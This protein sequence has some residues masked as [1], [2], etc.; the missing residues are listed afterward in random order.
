MLCSRMRFFIVLGLMFVFATTW[1]PAN[2]TV[3]DSTTKGFLKP[4]QFVVWAATADWTKNG[5]QATATGVN[6]GAALWDVHENLM[7]GGA[8]VVA[9][10]VP[11]AAEIGTADS[12][13][14]LKADMTDEQLRAYKHYIVFTEVMWG[15][16]SPYRK[17]AQ[18]L[19]LYCHSGL[20]KDDVI[21]MRQHHVLLPAPGETYMRDHD[22]DANTPERKYVVLDR[23][24]TVDR[25]GR[26]WALKGTNGNTDGNSNTGA[27]PENMV[28]MYRKIE[29]DS[30]GTGYQFENG[31][32]KGLGSG[33][34]ASSWEASTGRI[35]LWSFYTGSPG[36]VHVP[37]G[38]PTV[39]MFA[40]QPDFTELPNIIINEVRNDPSSLNFDWIELFY[41]SENA[42]DPPVNI[43]DYELSLVM[44]KMKDDGSGYHESGDANFTDTSL[45]VLPEYEMMPGEYLVVYNRDPGRT[46]PLADGVN[47]QDLLDETDIKKG[48]MHKYVVSTDLKL[49][50]EGKFLILLRTRNSADDV[51]KATNIKDY[52]GNGFFGRMEDRKFNTDVWPFVGWTKPGDV[53][54]NDFG[55]MNTFSSRS[56][57]FGRGVEINSQGMYGAK[58]NVNRVHK[59]DWQSFGF[60]G[61]GYDR[62]RDKTVD[63]M[64]SPGTPGYPNMAVNKV[65]EGNYTFKGTVTIS[66][67]MYDAGPRWNLVQWIELYNS[68]RTDTVNLENWKFEIRNENTQVESYVDAEF[69]FD[70]GTYIPPNQ[71]LL[72]VSSSGANDVPE[73]YVYNLEETHRSDLGLATRGRRLLSAEGF[74]LKLSAPTGTRNQ[75]EV[76]DEAGN[77]EVNGAMR[78]HAWDL[79]ERGEMRTSIVRTYGGVFNDMSEGSGPYDA[80]DGLMAASWRQSDLAGASLTFYG[81]RNDVG[82]PGYRLGSPL[83]V[84]LSSFRPVRDAVTGHVEISWITQSEL[85]NAGFNILR[86]ESKTGEFAVINTKGLIAGHGTTSERQVYRYTDT[87]AKPNVVYYYQI[88][89]VSM[90]GVRTTLRTTHLRGDVS[91]RGKLTTRWGDLKSSDQ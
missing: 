82:T 41:N 18:W 44:G 36:S 48:T 1:A 11:T 8:Y 38:G 74:Y 73:N 77:V 12:E 89:D 68:S 39:T 16:D 24:T 53:D 56:M 52:A 10:Q 43:K 46:V 13:Y 22:N 9:M 3:I 47:L 50:A 85:N 86:S 61:T 15:T 78:T 81:H 37:P 71:T 31:K 80:D 63:P 67:I 49:P 7:A 42:S 4:K 29:L 40:R 6:Q 65:S 19:E 87:T 88:E 75:M 66:E 58:S 84:S 76:M 25:F 14:T 23:V 2:L 79:P 30:T 17:D 34:E 27:L 32:L 35:N 64:D 33:A 20:K 5:I 54:D 26:L 62:G 91:A 90:D 72:L 45:A 51:G 57:S 83:P 55:G 70:A 69:K 21:A 60:M 59:N 28:S